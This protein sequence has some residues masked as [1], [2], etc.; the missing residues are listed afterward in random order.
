VAELIFGQDKN[1]I[2]QEFIE[3]LF[4]VF[5]TASVMGLLVPY[6]LKNIEEK[7]TV[8]QKRREAKLARQIKLIDAQGDLLEA[9]SSAFWKWRY[10]FIRVTYYGANDN[11][12]E[13]EAAWKCY[14]ESVWEILSQIRFQVSRSKWLVSNKQFESL[15]NFYHQIIEL[16]TKLYTSINNSDSIRRDVELGDLNKLIYG[17]IS[18]QL[19]E[20]TND[21]AIEMNISAESQIDQMQ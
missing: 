15:L 1:M 4:L 2:R 19:D 3:Q 14:C 21:L 7:K 20:L 17:E 11:S 8:E 10:S 12:E 16:D 18:D 13:C 5:I 9:I 6:L